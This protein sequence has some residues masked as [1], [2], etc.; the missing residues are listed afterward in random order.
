VTP[1]LRFAD[2]PLVSAG[3]RARSAAGR[4]GHV[5]A[6]RSEDGV[7]RVDLPVRLKDAP[8]F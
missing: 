4:F 1:S 7:E 8:D 6:V 3:E 5:A 2:D